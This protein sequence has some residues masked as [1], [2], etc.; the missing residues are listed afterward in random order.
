[1][2][3]KKKTKCMG[4]NMRQV[5]HRC[6]EYAKCNLYKDFVQAWMDLQEAV[7]GS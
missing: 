2:L 3:T 5:C 7:K 4:K 1:M 6:R